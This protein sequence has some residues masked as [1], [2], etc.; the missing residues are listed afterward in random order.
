MDA[1]TIGQ[2]A[3]KKERKC[4]CPQC[5]EWFTSGKSRYSHQRLAHGKVRKRPYS[6][7]K[8]IVPAAGLYA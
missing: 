3:N 5:Q 1:E 4:Q 8:R 6:P 7:T 2:K